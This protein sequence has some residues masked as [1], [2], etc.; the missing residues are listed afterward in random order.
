MDWHDER[1]YDSR[2]MMRPSAIQ[3]A[4][5]GGALLAACGCSQ[6]VGLTGDYRTLADAGAG[7]EPEL[8]G[9]GNFGATAGMVGSSGGGNADAG[10]EAGVNGGA[11]AGGVANGGASAAG[12]AHGGASAAGAANGGSAPSAGS[13]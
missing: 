8:A 5:W 6:L 2:S 13:G 3:L 10:A 1:R 12:A 7:G 4:V 9:S 11:S